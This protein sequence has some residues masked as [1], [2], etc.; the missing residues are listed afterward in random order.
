M[1]MHTGAPA[2]SKSSTSSRSVEHC[3]RRAARVSRRALTRAEGVRGRRTG[4]VN[5]DR[6][7]VISPSKSSV[8]L[9]SSQLISAYVQLST[10]LPSSSDSRTAFSL[11]SA[12]RQL[13]ARLTAP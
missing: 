10:V 5:W 2:Q 6:G 4:T 13:R 11:R 12:L 7:C 3:A 8:K 9:D 1:V